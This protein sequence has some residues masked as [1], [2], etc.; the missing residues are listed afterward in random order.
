[1]EESVGGSLC[2]KEPI[3]EGVCLGRSLFREE[4]L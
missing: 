1:M 3:Y 2:R 4:P